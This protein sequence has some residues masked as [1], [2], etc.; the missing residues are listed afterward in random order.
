MAGLT[1]PPIR[2]LRI[3]FDRRWLEAALRPS[4]VATREVV[5][6]FAIAA[7]LD[8]QTAESKVRPLL[9]EVGELRWMQWDEPALPSD[10][11]PAARPASDEVEG[12]RVRLEEAAIDAL[13]HFYL[14]GRTDDELIAETRRAWNSLQSQRRRTQRLAARE[15]YRSAWRRWGAAQEA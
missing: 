4:H 9:S 8:E 6:R 2:P 12:R 7:G 3:L 14:E 13:T 11:E 15:R 5:R 1:R 10:A